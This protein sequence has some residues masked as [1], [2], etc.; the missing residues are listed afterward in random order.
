VIEAEE[1]DVVFSVA[2]MTILGLLAMFLL[3]VAGALMH[4][5]EY[6]F[7]IWA[8]L[9][10]HQTPQVIASGFAYGT[11]AG[12]TATIVKLARV[13]LLAPVVFLAGI[14]HA[15]EQVKQHGSSER[16]NINYLHLFPMFI[17]G[18]LGMAFLR[19]IGFI[20]EVTFH[21]PNAAVFGAINPTINLATFFETVSQYCILI[22]MAG[23]GLET[24]FSAMKQTGAKPFFASLFASLLITVLILGL[25][26][27][28]GI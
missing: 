2:T 7:G 23:V 11:E 28:L 3:P 17:L 12:T 5:S 9:T 14:V 10:I 13:C 19:S 16:K 6:A 20:P 26:K 8:G 15:R 18:F 22:S 21:L 25:I 27:A 24:K 4:M 1:K